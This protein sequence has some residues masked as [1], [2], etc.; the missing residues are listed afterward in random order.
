MQ[1]MIRFAVANG[2]TG[3]KYTTKRQD[4]PKNATANL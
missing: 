3:P 4:V 1:N 2:L